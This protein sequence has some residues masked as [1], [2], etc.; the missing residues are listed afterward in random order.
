MLGLDDPYIGIS[1]LVGLGIG[2]VEV[3]HRRDVVTATHIVRQ[4]GWLGGRK[5]MIRLADIVRV[6]YSYPRFGERFRAGDVEVVANGQGVTFVGVAEPEDLA[7]FIMKARERALRGLAIE[8]QAHV[9]HN[10]EMQLT[11][12]AHRL[13]ERGPRS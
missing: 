7:T 5:Q 13:A 2:A 10:N 4:S 3:L 8:R 6:E 11:R 12:S 1:L 9:P